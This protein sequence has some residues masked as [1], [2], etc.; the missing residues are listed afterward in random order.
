[1]AISGG[2]GE[3]SLKFAFAK[4]KF[5][6]ILC[7]SHL[8]FFWSPIGENF[9]KKTLVQGRI[10][11]VYQD[12]IIQIQHLKLC[13]AQKFRCCNIYIFTCIK[14]REYIGALHKLYAMMI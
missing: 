2:G 12:K 10:G 9:Q 11:S 4:N 8:V 14:C 6:K 13:Y 3:K 5:T 1:M 7:I